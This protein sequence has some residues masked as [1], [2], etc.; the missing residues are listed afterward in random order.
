MIQDPRGAVDYDEGGSGPTLVLVPGSCGTGAAWRPVISAL[1]SGFRCVTTSLP[2]YGGTAERRSADDPSIARLAESV[3]A[4]VRRTAASVHLVGHSFGGLVATVVALRKQ[5]ALASLAVLEAPAVMSLRDRPDDAHHYRAFRDMTDAYF[6]RFAS[7]DRE[8]IR[9][10][11]DFYGGT[12][13]FASWPDRVRAYAM[14]T[15]VVNIRDWES[16]FGFPLSAEVFAKMEIPSLVGWGGNS[17]PAAQRANALL[18]ESMGAS[19][20]VT[21]A[22]AA[23]FMIATHA[24]EVAA[25]ISNHVA[26]VAEGHSTHRHHA[27]HTD[28]G[29]EASR[30]LCTN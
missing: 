12:G 30:L 27:T 9:L 3:E 6:A 8:A 1:G 5:V 19:R 17:H 2:G 29:T 16:A 7:G 11:I 26:D 15:T 21:I 20:S 10:M 22:G 14:D 25:I 24:T 13:T 18:A 23:H 28:V 4:V